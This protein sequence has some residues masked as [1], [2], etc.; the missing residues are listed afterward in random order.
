MCSL[1]DHAM[2]RSS[3]TEGGGR[4]CPLKP[5]SKKGLSAGSELLDQPQPLPVKRKVPSLPFAV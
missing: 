5:P 1:D 3:S 4:E 2:V